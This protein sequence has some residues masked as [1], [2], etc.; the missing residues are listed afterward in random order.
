[1][2]V[3]GWRFILWSAHVPASVS[4]ARPP[5]VCAASLRFHPLFPEVQSMAEAQARSDWWYCQVLISSLLSLILFHYFI[6][7]FVFV[8]FLFVD[9][10]PLPAQFKSWRSVELPDRDREW[11]FLKE[12]V[13]AFDPSMAAP[14]NG[15]SQPFCLVGC[16]VKK[17]L[18]DMSMC[19]SVCYYYLCVCRRLFEQLP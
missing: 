3:V 17:I 8:G 18:D 19:V 14:T 1:M 15:T 16:K 13:R 10:T 11:V 12:H 9:F 2:I 4:T 7:L 5:K 6:F